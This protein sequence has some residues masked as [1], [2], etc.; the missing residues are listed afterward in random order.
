M[1][2]KPQGWEI[3]DARLGGL[4]QRINTCQLRLKA[5]LSGKLER[6][7]EMEED[8]LP[9]KGFNNY[10]SLISSSLM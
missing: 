5:Y 8:I 6:L 10:T 4:I 2:Y 9:H 3:Q 1:P 7:E